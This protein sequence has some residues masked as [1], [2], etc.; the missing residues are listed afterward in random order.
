MN[1]ESANCKYDEGGKGKCSRNHQRQIAVV[2]EFCSCFTLLHCYLLVF[3]FCRLKCFQWLSYGQRGIV[4]IS[5]TW[6]KESSKLHAFKL[7]DSTFC[8]NFQCL[9]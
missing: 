3:C 6:L 4:K 9:P 5:K 2:N 8:L 7:K 1:C